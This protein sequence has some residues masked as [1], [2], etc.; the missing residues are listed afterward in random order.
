MTAQVQQA[1][2][3]DDKIEEL[4]EP[5]AASE[6]TQT[7]ERGWMEERIEGLTRDIQRRREAEVEIARL[8]D[9]VAG[10][11][12]AI[13]LPMHTANAHFSQQ[14]KTLS[15]GIELPASKLCVA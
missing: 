4:G 11:R 6:D 1:D 3:G 12:R 9:V 2:G 13:D 5:L 7:A 10:I 15:A 14:Q 8:G